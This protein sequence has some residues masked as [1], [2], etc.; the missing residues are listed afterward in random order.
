MLP[1]SPVSLA[2]C[3]VVPQILIQSLHLRVGE[4]EPYL[5]KRLLQQYLPAADVIR[6]PYLPCRKRWRIRPSVCSR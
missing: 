1:E 3:D 6:L 4:I 2:L 5:A